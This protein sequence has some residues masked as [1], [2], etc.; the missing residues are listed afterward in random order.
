MSHLQGG[1]L[2]ANPPPSGRVPPPCTQGGGSFHITSGDLFL[3]IGF[4]IL[5][6]AL[7]KVFIIFFFKSFFKEIES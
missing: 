6:A 4:L 3:K 1:G 5:E 2:G 7:L